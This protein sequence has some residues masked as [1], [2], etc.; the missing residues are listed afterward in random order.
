MGLN[1]KRPS[2]GNAERFHGIE[3]AFQHNPVACRRTWR[4]ST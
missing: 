4:A 3:W 1:S 2:S